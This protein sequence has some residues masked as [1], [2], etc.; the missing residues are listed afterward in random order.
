MKK[1]IISLYFIIACFYVSAQDKIVNIYD[2]ALV[3]Y[4]KKDFKKASYFYDVYYIDQKNTQSNYDTY[5][6]AIAAAHVGNFERAKYY[7]L[8]SAEIGYDVSSYKLFADDPDNKPL[9]NL[10]EWKKFI[11]D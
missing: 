1:L 11:G 8:R 3:Y 9:Q 7:L 10:S 2:S 6:A 4:K 5:Y